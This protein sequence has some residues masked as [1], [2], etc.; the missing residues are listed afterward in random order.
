MKIYFN[1]IFLEFQ[2]LLKRIFRQFLEGFKE[3]KA[4]V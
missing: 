2:I 4:N 3:I 1:L